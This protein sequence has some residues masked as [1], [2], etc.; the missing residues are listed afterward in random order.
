MSR[1]KIVIIKKLIFLN[2]IFL[3]V[4]KGDNGN[5]IALNEELDFL[6]NQRLKRARAH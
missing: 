4:D 5:R 6:Q 1:V 2:S 3:L